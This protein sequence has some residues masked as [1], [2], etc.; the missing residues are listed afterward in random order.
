MTAGV[1]VTVSPVFLRI[2]PILAPL[3]FP[4]PVP[5]PLAGST[6]PPPAASAPE[7][8]HLYFL[9]LL[10]DPSHRLRHSTVSQP[11]PAQ[12]LEIPYDDNEWVEEQLVGVIGRGIEVLGQD[13]VARRMGLLG[14]GAEVEGEGEEVFDVAKE[15]GG[16][17]EEKGM[18]EA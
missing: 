11:V 18:Q 16:A 7:K 3:P 12:W 8:P 15:E 5:T 14:P 9:L 13:Y 4:Y 17:K 6:A 1:P 10:S 2:Q